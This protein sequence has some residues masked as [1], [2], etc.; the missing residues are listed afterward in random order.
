MCND[1]ENAFDKHTKMVS[2]RTTLN[3]LSIETL[4]Q[5]KGCLLTKR[6]ES[7]DKDLKEEGEYL[8]DGIG[9][10]VSEYITVSEY[11]DKTT[12]SHV[13][14]PENK[15]IDDSNRTGESG[16][17]SS[18]LDS[19]TLNTF[20]CCNVPHVSHQQSN[21][22]SKSWGGGRGPLWNKCVQ[23]SMES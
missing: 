7:I 8:D 19:V 6:R 11:N 23:G 14:G 5:K 15:S 9:E 12:N 1:F 3:Q 22:D 10:N 17:E 18:A 21:V 20:V 16:D 4:Q 13:F 2:Q